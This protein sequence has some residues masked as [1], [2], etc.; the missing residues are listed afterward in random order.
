MRHISNERPVCY[1]IECEADGPMPK[2]RKANSNCTLSLT[3]RSVRNSTLSSPALQSNAKPLSANTGRRLKPQ[4]AGLPCA[5]DRN[6]GAVPARLPINGEARESPSSASL[7]TTNTHDADEQRRVGEIVSNHSR[8]ERTGVSTISAVLNHDSLQPTK[9]STVPNITGT[10][11]PNRS[12]IVANCN[13]SAGF[14]Q[15]SG[16]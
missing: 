8:L 7:N 12:A 16:K 15:G 2:R 9:E 11:N 5:E 14:R 1:L 6:A 10:E 4:A 3:G 13:R